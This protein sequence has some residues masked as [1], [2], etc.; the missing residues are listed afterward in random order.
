MVE[1]K[2]ILVIPHDLHHPGGGTCVAAWALQALA[3]RHEVSVLSWQ[4]FDLRI[5]NR[6]FGTSLRQEDV[7]VFT[8]NAALRSAVSLVP[9]PLA[10]LRSQI[11]YRVAKSLYD[12]G[13]FDVVFSAS[14]EIDIGGTAIQYIHFPWAYWP[15]PEGELRWYHVD[16]AVKAYRKLSGRLSGYDQA[17][18]AR[19]LSLANSNW[20]ARRFEE[21]YGALPRTLYPPVPGGYPET[22]HD[23]RERA[24][25]TVGRISPEKKIEEIIE[26]LAAV[27]ARGHD[28]RLTIIGHIEF[29]NYMRW[30][31]EKSWPHR[32]WIT[33]RHDLPRCD[34]VNLIARHRYGIHAMEDE[35]FGIAPAELQRAGCITFVPN[36]GG[37]P[38]I[39]GGDERVIFGSVE[40]AVEKIDR[41]LRDPALEAS[42]QEDVARRG[43]AFSEERFMKEILEVVEAF[44]PAAAPCA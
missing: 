8:V 7:Q 34:L 39:V 12:E 44:R 27:R 35:H 6:N 22:P 36:S 11:L 43:E 26:I 9:L 14:N 33:F 3:P 2:R 4:P 16:P 13:R 25:V 31:A 1:R 20:T 15:R 18:I 38:E 24:F 42:L 37:P 28:L 10:Y 21:W 17:R 29:P 41:V 5:T 19:N 40:D 23:R 30:L 32:S